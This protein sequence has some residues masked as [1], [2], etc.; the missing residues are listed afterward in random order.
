VP[1]NVTIRGANN[2]QQVFDIPV[3]AGSYLVQGA[4]MLNP[5]TSVYCDLAVLD[6]TQV[7]GRR[8]IVPY[9]QA[10]A[11]DIIDVNAR[12]VSIQAVVTL[13]QDS[14]LELMCSNQDPASTTMFPT[15]FTALRLGALHVTT[16]LGTAVP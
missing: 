7:S 6:S 11:I 13:S 14:T 4:Y 10:A 5:G 16:P 8:V 3:P 12:H 9:A 15:S 1:L 2:Y